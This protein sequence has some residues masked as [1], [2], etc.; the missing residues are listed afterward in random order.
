LAE[1]K[2]RDS[3]TNGDLFLDGDHTRSIHRPVPIA[4]HLSAIHIS[5]HGVQW[6]N[7]QAMVRVSDAT[8]TPPNFPM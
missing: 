5:F 1:G 4:I 2:L 8:K 6:V 7:A 3:R